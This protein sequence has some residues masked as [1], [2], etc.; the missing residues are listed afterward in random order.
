MNDES[1]KQPARWVVRKVE[2]TDT[3]TIVHV[4]Q[5]DYMPDQDWPKV[6][7]ALILEKDARKEATG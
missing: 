3:D 2:Q 5:T 7:D 1:I 6:G 4:A